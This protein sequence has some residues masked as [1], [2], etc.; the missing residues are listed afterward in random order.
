MYHDNPIIF[1]IEQSQIQSF[2]SHYLGSIKV[3]VNDLYSSMQYKCC[4]QTKLHFKTPSRINIWS[5]V[6]LNIN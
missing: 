3:Y 1:Y 6:Y 2:E 5:R 4:P